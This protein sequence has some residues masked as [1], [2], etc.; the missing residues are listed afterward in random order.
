[1]VVS[2]ATRFFPRLVL[3][4]WALFLVLVLLALWTFHLG[5]ALLPAFWSYL[6]SA[7]LAAELVLTMSGGHEIPAATLLAAAW[8]C[9][10]LYLL[11]HT[12]GG[13]I[14]TQELRAV[15]SAAVVFGVAV[16]GRAV[17][18]LAGA[19]LCAVLWF[20]CSPWYGGAVKSALLVFTPAAVGVLTISV[21]GTMA[22]NLYR[23]ALAILA[24]L[25]P[26][27]IVGGEAMGSSLQKMLP[28]LL[29]AAGAVL[30]RIVERRAGYGDLV[31]LALL[32]YLMASLSLGKVPPMMTVLDVGMILYAGAMSLLSLG[33]PRRIASLV[34]LTAV[35]CV[36]LWV[37]CRLIDAF[38]FH[39]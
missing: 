21:M 32:M 34:F 11:L 16:H 25:S 22:P 20:K 29:F 24:A 3:Q 5:R 19:F 12:V 8:S 18:M 14:V 9:L 23:S 26:D 1:L 2:A 35:L 30:S 38:N 36:S 39:F 28:A 17:V 27:Q 7:L 10:L 6:F 15:A 13:A 37:Q 33:P 31:Y 4:G